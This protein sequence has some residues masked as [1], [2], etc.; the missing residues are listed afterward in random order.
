[1][2]LHKRA[3]VFRL[4]LHKKPDLFVLLIYKR[5]VFAKN[6]IKEMMTSLKLLFLSNLTTICRNKVHIS[7]NK[8]HILTNHWNRLKET[9][10]II[11]QN[12]DYVGEKILDHLIS[13]YAQFVHTKYSKSTPSEFQTLRFN[14]SFVMTCDREV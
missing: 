2:D 10:P 5:N 7:S 9:I 12:M 1:M 8:V 11:S 14:E 13:T 6:G 4:Y 3:A